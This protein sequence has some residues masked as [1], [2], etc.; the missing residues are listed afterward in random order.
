M[1]TVSCGPLIRRSSSH[2]NLRF[3]I[4]NLQLPL[5]RIIE[6]ALKIEFP[7]AI[8]ECRIICRVDEALILD[9]IEK[10]PLRDHFRDF[11][12]VS[13]RDNFRVFAQLACTWEC[14]EFLRAF[15]TRK[16]P[17]YFPKHFIRLQWNGVRLLDRVSEWPKLEGI[18]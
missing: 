18:F 10:T 14:Q 16:H 5:R 6:R 8:G 3:E 12:I 1:R 13:Q 11:R 7:D 15:R 2:R 4:F 9:K 17:A